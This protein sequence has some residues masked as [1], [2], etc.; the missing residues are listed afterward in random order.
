MNKNYPK[1]FDNFYDKL[2]SKGRATK[3]KNG[4]RFNYWIENGEIYTNMEDEEDSHWVG[5]EWDKENLYCDML[6]NYLVPRVKEY[7]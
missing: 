2:Q 1:S 6:D 3:T 5:S 7:V 4:W